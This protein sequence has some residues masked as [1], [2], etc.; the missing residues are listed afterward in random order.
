MKT[1]VYDHQFYAFV[2]ISRIAGQSLSVLDLETFKTLKLSK[3]DKYYLFSKINLSLHQL[4]PKRVTHAEQKSLLQ[5]LLVIYITFLSS[6][7]LY[8]PW[9]SQLFTV[10]PEGM[11]LGTTL[12]KNKSASRARIYM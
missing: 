12:P 6:R 11:E 7:G 2:S 10:R 8:R 3:N 1:P 4:N 9:E 5:R